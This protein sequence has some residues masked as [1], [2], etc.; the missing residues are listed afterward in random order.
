M[1]QRYLYIL[2]QAPYASAAGVEALEA[3][4]TS[5]N[6]DLRVSILLL[7]DGIYQIKAGQGDELKNTG[8]T[9]NALQDFGIQDLFIDQLSLGARG[10]TSADLA[11][12]AKILDAQEISELV[13]DC[14]QVITF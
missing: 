2:A 13:A 4:I 14:H 11:V 7:H 6:F 10:L 9:F 8:K 3:A 12:P 5:A 1:N